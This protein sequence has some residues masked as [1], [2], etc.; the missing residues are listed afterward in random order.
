MPAL[1]NY[2]PLRCRAR[3]PDVVNPP[4]TKL[5]N[6]GSQRLLTAWTRELSL[7][8]GTCVKCDRTQRARTCCPTL[9]RTTLFRSGSVLL[10]AADFRH[11]HLC[12][13]AE[14][15]QDFEHMHFVRLASAGVRRIGPDGAH[16][17]SDVPLLQ[18]RRHP[19]QPSRVC[20]RQ[21]QIT[22]KHCAD[23]AVLAVEPFN[24]VVW[25]GKAGTAHTSQHQIVARLC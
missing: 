10:Q 17:P 7:R 13:C 3:I 22:S 11:L 1:T 6:T 8:W 12:R 5:F 14:G 2:R 21:S 16:S 19:C 15:R 18:L 25:H 23:V 9:L 20:R 24:T 4:E